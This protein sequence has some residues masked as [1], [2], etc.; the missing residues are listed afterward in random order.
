MFLP[1]A[2]SAQAFNY[3]YNLKSGGWS[4]IVS[5]KVGTL[6]EVPALKALDISIIVGADR[7]I[8][9]PVT[10]GGMLSRSFPVAKQAVG[11][12]GITGRIT[13]GRPPQIGGIV[14]GVSFKL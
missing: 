10:F 2:A 1:V 4:P 6:T 14:I 7:S 8:S 13:S 12:I 11:L 9:G 5:Q 3:E